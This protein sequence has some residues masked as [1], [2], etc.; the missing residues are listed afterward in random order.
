M[1]AGEALLTT[2]SSA[3][4]Y[5]VYIPLDDPIYQELDTLN[6]LGFLDDYLAEIKPISRIE[7]AR[8]TLEARRNMASSGEHNPLAEALADRLRLELADEINWINTETE[9]SLP[10]M[11]HPLER[12]EAAYIYSAGGRRYWDTG[13]TDADIRLNASEGTPLLPNND[14]I[15]TGAGSN[16]VV[17]WSG[18]GGLAGFLTGYGEVE[19]SGPFTRSL[20]GSSRVL[21]LNAEAVMGLGNHALSFG[22]EEMWW[23]TGHF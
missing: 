11:L 8:L 13:G 6:G 3:S 9:D 14:G 18:W 15:A 2:N 10:N 20:S 16:E 1:L 17:R 12:L 22:Q 5:V 23:G 19:A 21:P 4:T 7:A